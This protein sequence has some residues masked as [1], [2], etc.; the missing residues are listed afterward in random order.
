M[1]DYCKSITFT[2]SGK[3]YVIRDEETYQK[4]QSILGGGC[5]SR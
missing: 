2:K 5:S 4:V 3:T 1:T